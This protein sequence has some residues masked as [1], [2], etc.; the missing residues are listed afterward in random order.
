MCSWL[1]LLQCSTQENVT[2]HFL[3]S[4]FSHCLAA[5]ARLPSLQLCHYGIWFEGFPRH[6][7]L[8]EPNTSSPAAFILPP[9]SLSSSPSYLWSSGPTGLAMRDR[10]HT[11]IQQCDLGVSKQLNIPGF[12]FKREL[13]WLKRKQI[14]L[15]TCRLI[16]QGIRRNSRI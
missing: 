16:F 3:G 9:S 1:T 5:R 10:P 4:L 14:C 15:E 6:H 7:R 2:S 8:C 12:A 11:H 13:I